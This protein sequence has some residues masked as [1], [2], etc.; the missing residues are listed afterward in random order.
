MI[1]KIILDDAEH[2]DHGT[3]TLNDTYTLDDLILISRYQFNRNITYHLR[4]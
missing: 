4:H 3:A 1:K 2:K